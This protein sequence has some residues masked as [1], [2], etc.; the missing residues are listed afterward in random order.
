MGKVNWGRVFVGGLLGGL[1]WNILG[2]AVWYF[3][4]R[5][6]WKAAM[7]ALGRPIQETTGMNIFWVVFTFVAGILGV[8]L[9]AAIRPRFGPGPKTAACAGFTYWLI[10]GLLPTVAWGTSLGFPTGLLATDA[11]VGL[12]LTVIAVMAGAWAYKE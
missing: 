4:L 1:V 10:G 12:I 2:L 8:Y 6:P 7:D 9:Y 11:V 5:E 3:Y